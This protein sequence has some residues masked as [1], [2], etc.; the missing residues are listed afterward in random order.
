MPAPWVDVPISLYLLDTCERQI[1]SQRRHRQSRCPCGVQH[2]EYKN[3]VCIHKEESETLLGVSRLGGV[4]PN[5]LK[6]KSKSRSGS[7]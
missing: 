4:R 6:T 1:V 7:Q 3:R 2:E 5:A